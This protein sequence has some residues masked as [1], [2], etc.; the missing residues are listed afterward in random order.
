LVGGAERQNLRV[1]VLG[2][3]TWGDYGG[4][5]KRN[6]WEQTHPKWASILVGY[7]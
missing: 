3:N 4:R 1:G 7:A 5:G 2:A 6:G